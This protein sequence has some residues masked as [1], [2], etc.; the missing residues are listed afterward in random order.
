MEYEHY[1]FDDIP[2]GKDYVPALNINSFNSK[3]LSGRTAGIKTERQHDL[4][5]L[6]EQRDFCI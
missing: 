6:N 2:R 1:N 5:S 3:E 4:L